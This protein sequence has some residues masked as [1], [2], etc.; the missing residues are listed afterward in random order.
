MEA[1]AINNI[2]A[3]VNGSTMPFTDNAMCAD[4]GRKV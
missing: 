4:N 3:A 1:L 2:S